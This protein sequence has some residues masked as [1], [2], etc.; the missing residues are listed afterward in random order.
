MTNDKIV[1]GVR[2][3]KWSLTPTGL[4]II[5]V[6]AMSGLSPHQAQQLAVALVEAAEDA[7]AAS[8]VQLEQDTG[9][10][11]SMD[12]PLDFPVAVG[13]TLPSTSHEAADSM[14]PVIAQ[15]RQRIIEFLG[16]SINGATDDEIEARLGMKHQTAS[17]ARRGL[18]VAGLVEDSGQ[19]RKTRSG[20]NAIVWVLVQANK[21]TV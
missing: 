3:V 21:D 18:V 2:A 11:M 14:E 20:R 10:Q 17:A 13:A 4:P 12:A 1:N 8:I 9:G 19:T 6:I 15:V 5:S 16:S 7:H